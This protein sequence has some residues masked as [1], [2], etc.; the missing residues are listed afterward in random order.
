M[1][2]TNHQRVAGQHLNNVFIY[3]PFFFEGE[4]L[5]F[6]IVRAHWVDVGGMSTGFGGGSSVPDP[7]LEGLQFDQL[8]I[9][10]A[11]MP[12]DDDAA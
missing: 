5:A 3:M 12:D 6:A 2:I 4:L 8:K 1:L 10:E 11:G 9:Y 7:W